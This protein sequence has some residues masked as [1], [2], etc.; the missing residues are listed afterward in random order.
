[1][2]DRFLNILLVVI[3]LA[4]VTVILVCALHRGNKSKDTGIS[5]FNNFCASEEKKESLEVDSKRYKIRYV[6]INHGIKEISINCNDKI[7]FSCADG[8]HI[9]HNFEDRNIS[10]RPCKYPQQ[11]TLVNGQIGYMCTDMGQFTDEHIE[12]MKD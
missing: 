4:L 12:C 8:F 3:I 6:D 1:M 2:K 11:I 5:S 10:N 7:L 9:E